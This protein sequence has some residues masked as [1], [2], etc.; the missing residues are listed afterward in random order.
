MTNTGNV[1]LSNI[2]F[3][4]DA[5]CTK[6]EAELLSPQ[7]QTTC[8][9]SK[10][11]TQDDFEAGSISWSAWVSAIPLGTNST[12]LTAN[13][14]D[15][16]V[17][18]QVRQLDVDMV[19]VVSLDNGTTTTGSVAEANTTVVLLVTASNKGNVHLRNVT[20][21]VPGLT[22]NLS[23]PG[24]ELD[25]E[26]AVDQRIKCMGSFHFDQDAF[27]AGSRHFTAVASASMLN[28]SISSN[29]VSVH[30]AASPQL[31]VNVDALQCTKPSRM[32]K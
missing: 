10:N 24:L 12:Q 30:V 6:A 29:A 28:S 3:G 8:S 26:L 16:R 13:S 27:E 2:T 18:N 23:C 4:G 17:L 1:R 21:A 7:A 20:L 22:T 11:S 25:M 19:R 5:N 31:Q 14:T 15:S 32:C 9:F